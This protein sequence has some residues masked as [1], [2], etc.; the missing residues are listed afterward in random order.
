MNIFL[1]AVVAMAFSQ[2]SSA[3]DGRGVGVQLAKCAAYQS[4][5]GILMNAN[6]QSKL[7][8]DPRLGDVGI[9][10]NRRIA[11]AYGS[12]ANAHIPAEEVKAIHAS[13]LQKE[14]AK[15]IRELQG[16]GE[17]SNSDRMSLMMTECFALFK[18][19]EKKYGPR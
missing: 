5:Q 10:L 2:I 14:Y 11:Q 15:L 4:L 8:D 7:V 16:N 12:M 6:R 3:E 18:E 17:A 13:E 19:Q 1:L 9:E